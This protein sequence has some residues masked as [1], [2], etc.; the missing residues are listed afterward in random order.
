MSLYSAPNGFRDH[1]T[2]PGP[3]FAII[4]SQCVHDEIGLHCPHPLTD[5]G[6][7]FRR[8]RHPVARRKHRAR[9]CVESRTQRAAALTA[10]VRND[11]P[12]GPGP[13]PQ[14]ES[15][16]ARAPPVVRLKGPLALGHG[17]ISSLRVAPATHADERI[18]VGTRLPLVSSS[19]SL[20]GAVSGRSWVAAVSPRSG[21]CSRV[22]T[23]FRW[24]KPRCG[25]RCHSPI[26]HTRHSGHGP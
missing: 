14:P 22:L 13:H 19:V 2:N 21:D 18:P 7:E 15:V 17:C 10:P 1:Q 23:R 5:R 9:S 8:P 4:G 25:H 6:T 3:V 24:V 26:L 11:G 16:L 20:V 12:P